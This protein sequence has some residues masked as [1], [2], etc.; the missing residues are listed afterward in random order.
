AAASVVTAACIEIVVA[1]TVALVSAAPAALSAAPS[2][3]TH[4]RQLLSSA[5][6]S[7]RTTSAGLKAQTASC[8]KLTAHSR[9]T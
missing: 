2:V 1:E 8:A 5:P 9:I 4:G 7:L 3:E 6:V